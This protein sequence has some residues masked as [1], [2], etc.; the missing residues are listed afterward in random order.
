MK[1][2]GNC[3][4]IRIF[5]CNSNRPL[6]EKIVKK[7]DGI[8]KSYE[9]SFECEKIKDITLGKSDVSRFQDGEI[10]LKI[11][12]SI[13]ECDV[14]LIQST[15]NP[16]NDNLMELLIMIDAVKR[17]S[18]KRITAVIPYYGYARQDRK[19]RARDPISAKLV[20]N[21]LTSAGA[22]R[23]LTMDLHS[24]QIQGFFDIPLDNLRGMPLFSHY[25]KN[26]F[27][28]FDDIIVVSPD[29]GSVSR[30][31]ALAEKLNVNL[32][33]IDK[34]RPKDDVTEVVN[35]I[36]KVKGKKAIIIDDEID[37]GGSIINASN[38]LIEK[39]VTDV[40][41]CCTH[42]KFSGNAIE[43]IEKSGISEIVTL[44]TINVDTKNSEKLKI[45]SVDEMFALAIYRIHG[46]M[47]V[48]DLFE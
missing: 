33:I 46:G 10:S 15:S 13:R 24:A 20:S 48:S 41:V 17:A 1:D 35:I 21:L 37:T 5:T 19:V 31:R 14:Y 4:D 7:L 32:A 25:Y 47:S 45:L 39:G 3:R 42:G 38:A 34:R 28:N 12:E 30:S 9:E 43:K 18:A 8:I 26:K 6:A 44:D 16:V 22:D 40:Y 23:I 27:D 11:H 29:L 36:G 2:S